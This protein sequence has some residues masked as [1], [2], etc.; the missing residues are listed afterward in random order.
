MLLPPVRGTQRRVGA[1]EL[2]MK[3]RESVLLLVEGL[4]SG[5]DHLGTSLLDRVFSLD[6]E[7]RGMCWMCD[8]GELDTVL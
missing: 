8:V 1:F 4:M 2:V 3:G 5:I 6:E 7:T